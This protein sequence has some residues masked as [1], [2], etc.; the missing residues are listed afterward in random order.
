MICSQYKANIRCKTE[1]ILRA[2]DYFLEKCTELLYS[3]ITTLKIGH[4][5]YGRNSFRCLKLLKQ[6]V[7]SRV[8]ELNFSQHE[9]VNSEYFGLKT[10]LRCRS[11]FLLV[12]L[13]N[14]L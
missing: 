5:F 13:D 2:G 9:S 8:T 4:F 14:A 6:K 12:A 7:C 1:I 3:L 10:R 11:R